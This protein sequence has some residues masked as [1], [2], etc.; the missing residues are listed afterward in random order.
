MELPW[1]IQGNFNRVQRLMFFQ[2]NVSR[3]FTERFQAGQSQIARYDPRGRPVKYNPEEEDNAEEEGDVDQEHLVVA[4]VSD[5]ESDQEF[6]HPNDVEDGVELGDDIDDEY[7][8]ENNVD[9][10]ADMIDPFNNN[11]SGPDDDIDEEVDDE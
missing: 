4:Y 9:D 11:D 10:D 3:S 2:V 6:D 1:L 8:T 5:E 7:I